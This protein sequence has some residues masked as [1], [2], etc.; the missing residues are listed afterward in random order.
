MMLGITL[1][2]IASGRSISRTGRY[3]RFPIAGLALMTLALALLASLATTPSR[4]SIAIGLAIFGLGFGMVGQVLIAAV[5]NAVDRRQL[6]VAMA[7]T[8]FFRALGGALGAATLGAVF[9]A[10]ESLHPTRPEIIEGV[11]T[12]FLTAAPLA[13]LALA[14][15]LLL[16]EVPLTGRDSP[17]HFQQQDRKAAGLPS[18]AA[19]RVRAVRNGAPSSEASKG[20]EARPERTRAPAT[21]TSTEKP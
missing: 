14:I 10:H 12:V 8:S 19:Q 7:T 6:G 5:Q 21:P 11:Q 16:K 20:A 1:S 9:A 4:T 17:P 15:V 3:K 2:T 13:A 18:A